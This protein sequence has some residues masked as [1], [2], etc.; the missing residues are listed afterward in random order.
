MLPG[1]FAGPARRTGMP[2]RFAGRRNRRV[3]PQLYACITA[4]DARGF[5]RR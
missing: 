4:T 3:A 2:D 1:F 5:E